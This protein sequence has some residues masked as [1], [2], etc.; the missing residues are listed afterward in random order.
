MRHCLGRL[1]NFA[2][3]SASIQTRWSSDSIQ[4]IFHKCDIM[5]DIICKAP[6]AEATVCYEEEKVKLGKELTPTQVKDVPKMTWDTCPDAY[7]SICMVDPDA[8]CRT[9]PSLRNWLHWLVVN[10]PGQC[11]SDGQTLTEYV[12][13]APP[14]DT[15]IHRYVFLVYKQCDKQYFHEPTI[16][17][18]S[19]ENRCN[20]DLHQFTKKYSL[21]DPIAGNLFHAKWDCYVPELQKQLGIEP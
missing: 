5:P 4:C 17:A 14:K 15:G 21:K 1:L 11:F 12:G 16:T 20:F 13:A 19:A 10:I 3:T 6:E 7:Y 8:P 18:C 2:K 9:A